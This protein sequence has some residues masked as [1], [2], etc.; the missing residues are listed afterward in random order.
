M[1]DPNTEMPTVG[2]RVDILNDGRTWMTGTV[3]GHGTIVEPSHY[4]DELDR[5]VPSV[6]RPVVLVQ[7]DS[8]YRG[9]L[10]G[11]ANPWIDTII[12]A[13]DAVRVPARLVDLEA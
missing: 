5:H 12:V 6:M 13:A 8:S 11:D 3:H 9:H 7:L 1:N 4:D 2:R 10:P